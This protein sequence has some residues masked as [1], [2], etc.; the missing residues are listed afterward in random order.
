MH[1]TRQWS[2]GAHWALPSPEQLTPNQKPKK[3]QSIKTSP[4]LN[5]S[6]AYARIIGQDDACTLRGGRWSRISIDSAIFRSG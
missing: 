6:N 5:P 4:D 2:E 1:E 3:K